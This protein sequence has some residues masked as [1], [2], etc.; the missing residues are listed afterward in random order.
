MFIPIRPGGHQSNMSL[1]DSRA[2][3]R[4]YA[5][6]LAVLAIAMAAGVWID[7]VGRAPFFV[8]IL[9]AFC[10]GFAAQI[11]VFLFELR[12]KLRQ[13]QPLFV[14]LPRSHEPLFAP[15]DRR[16]LF[17]PPSLRWAAIRSVLLAF[18]LGYRIEHGPPIV[19]VLSTVLLIALALNFHCILRHA[20]KSEMDPS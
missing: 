11:G 16:R 15:F 19:D 6:L 7:V 3:I 13:L 1:T 12:S 18:M 8:S 2:K 10:A 9:I 5:A 14:G 20:S 17:R 4:E